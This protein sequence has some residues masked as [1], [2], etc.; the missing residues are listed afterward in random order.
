MGRD[1]GGGPDTRD[2]LG[3]A[4]IGL[5]DKPVPPRPLAAG[6]R[7]TLSRLT[8]F[9]A[10]RRRAAAPTPFPHSLSLHASCSSSGFPLCIAIRI[11]EDQHLALLPSRRP[12]LRTS[13]PQSV[14][15]SG[16][17]RTHTTQKSVGRSV[18]HRTRPL[19]NRYVVLYTYAPSR[20]HRCGR[21]CVSVR[22]ESQGARRVSECKPCKST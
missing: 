19:H 18:L 3:A 10:S 7:L 14:G 16:T 5:G 12:V 1:C 9:A 4:Q 13:P 8:L 15:R 21:S 17:L 22:T 2:G 11:A 6:G 20:E